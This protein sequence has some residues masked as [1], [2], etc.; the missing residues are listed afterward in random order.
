MSGQYLSMGAYAALAL[1]VIGTVVR[2]AYIARMP[3]HLRWELAPVPGEKGK[4]QYGGSYLEELDWWTKKREKSLLAEVL[5]MAREI[6]LLHGVWRNN[7]LL[8]PFSYAFHLGIY[9]VAVMACLLA[10]GNIAAFIHPLGAL[11]DVLL[12][13]AQFLGSAGYGAGSL[14]AVGLFILRL[15]N[16]NFRRF[17]SRA[18]YGNLLVVAMMLLSGLYAWLRG[19]GAVED[20][21]YFIGS[22]M[23]GG[24]SGSLGVPIALHLGLSLLFLAVLPYTQM[25]HFIAKYFTYHRVLWDDRPTGEAEDRR[26]AK[27]LGGPISWSAGHVN[28]GGAKT[29]TDTVKGDTQNG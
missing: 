18:T 28:G 8:W 10:A 2:T 9:L 6:F 13:A 3:A 7:R 29:W 15:G 5:F 21:Y 27:R 20:L 16:G 25:I 26:M 11:E 4:D 14:G 19:D 23:S 17:S 22:L 12:A 24:M 1:F